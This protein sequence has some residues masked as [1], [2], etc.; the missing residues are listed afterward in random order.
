M[1]QW[2]IDNSIGILGIIVGSF[3]AYH[4][5]FLSKKIEFKDK[6]VHKDNIRALVEPI[7]YRIANGYNRKSELIN[8]KKYENHYPNDNKKNRHGYTYTSGELKALRY[9]GVEFFCNVREVYNKPDGKLTFNKNCG[10][11]RAAY[12]VF[13]VG[14]IPYE[15]I[16]YIYNE[17]DEFF[18]GPRFFVRFKGVG[19]SPYKYFVHYRI[20]DTYQ[21]GDPIDWEYTKID[22]SDK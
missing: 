6:L 19:K 2:L 8:I 1:T 13:D 11:P 21:K 5:Y 15:W 14:L 7:L 3:I 9:D 12:N 10:F 4:V 18:S 20:N 16:E 17:G 22:I